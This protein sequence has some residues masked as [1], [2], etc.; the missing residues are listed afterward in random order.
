MNENIPW[1]GKIEGI[2]SRQIELKASFETIVDRFAAFEGTVILLSGGDL[3]C[4]RYHILAA[5]PWLQFRGYG[6]RIHITTREKSTHFEGDSFDTLR[7]ISDAFRI[8]ENDLPQPVAAG[9]FGYLGYDLKD[10]LEVLPRTTINDLDLPDI[11]FFAP[12]IILIEDKQSNRIDLIIPK[13][14]DGKKQLWEA[15][16]ADFERIL[17]KPALPKG[18]FSGDAAGFQ[19][20][21][22]RPVY[23][24]AVAKIKDYIAAGHV[25]QVNMSQRF[26]MDFHGDGYAFFQALY[27]RNP[28]PFYAYINAG[29]HQVVS[30]SPERFLCLRDKKVETRPIK[31]T[32]PRG[33]NTTEDDQFRQ[34]LIRSKK[35]DAELSMIVD[36][37]RNDLG[38]VCV[39]G[40]VKVVEHKRLEAYQNVYHLVS[41]VTGEL[42]EERDT[43]D[44]IKATFPGG[45]ITGCPKIRAMEIIDELEPSCRHVYTGA[46]GYLGFH[47][48]MDLNIAIRTA[49]VHND[50]ILFSVGGGIVFDS[51]PADEYEETLHKGRTLMTVFKDTS[52]YKSLKNYAWVNGVIKPL[53]EVTVGVATPGFQYGYGFFETIFSVK[54]HCPLLAD[55]LARFNRTWAH[56]MPGMPPDLSWETII[57]QV[58]TPNE[59]TQTTAAVKIIA[60]R[61]DRENP[62]LNH[63]LIVTARPYTHRLDALESTGIRLATYP[64]ARQTPLADHKT[65]NYLYYLLAGRWAQIQGVHEALILNPDGTISETNTAS[66]LLVKDRTVCRPTSPHVLPG[67]MEQAVCR[68]L[69]SWGYQITHAKMR[70]SDLFSYDEVLLTNALMGAVPVLSLDRRDLPS[71][72]DLWQRINAAVLSEE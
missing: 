64:E 47:G 9:L 41:I 36:L 15:D 72:S 26:G 69:K 32:R 13:R 18:A 71:P 3:D 66:I 43:I 11:C 33:K 31:G 29:D 52:D 16:L 60:A 44:L 6:Q 61:G 21:F 7:A 4:A 1:T 24:N 38:K 70:P 45:S 46:I 40:S 42:K 30:T 63:T 56:L 59:L 10:H 28:A 49:V 39:A 58:L 25:Y 67:V 50:E 51:D 14:V 19:S 37:L 12:A 55:H 34:E 5:R 68:Q 53:E 20:N 27:E 48:T 22:T 17:K 57:D 8:E 62:P 65:L 23:E 54:G 35:D 2:F